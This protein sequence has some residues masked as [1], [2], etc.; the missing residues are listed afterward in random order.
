MGEPWPSGGAH[1]D[2]IS[3]CIMRSRMYIVAGI[4]IYFFRVSG[5]Q[6]RVTFSSLCKVDMLAGLKYRELDVNFSSVT[7]TL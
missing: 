2:K 6:V 3:T 5:V 4:G 7:D 1:G